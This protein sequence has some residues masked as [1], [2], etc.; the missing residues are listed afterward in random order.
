MAFALFV[1]DAAWAFNARMDRPLIEEIIPLSGVA[2]GT[3]ELENQEEQP[4]VLEIYLQDWEYLEGGSGD[5][6]FSAPGSSPWSA[7]GWISFYP[8][9][10]EL[11]AHGKGMVEYTIRVPADARA[12]GHY[13]VMFFESK[14]GRAPENEQ[15]VSVHYTGRLGSLIEVQVA[16]TVERTGDITN[17]TVGAFK[18]DAPLTLGYI[19]RNTGNI[20]IRPKASFNII[21][22]TG[23]YFGRGEFKQLYTFPG[24]S[25]SVTTEWNG[26]LPSGNYTVVV[27]ADLGEG[28]AVVAEEPLTVP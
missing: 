3:I 14:L 20:A 2:H 24:R 19:F 25:G 6:L 17:V 15:G 4:A 27:T 13:S 1:P 7:S 10:L 23:R 16:G 9:K 26:T 21:D 11:P 12:G 22:Q 28:Q 5:K 18:T 8:Q